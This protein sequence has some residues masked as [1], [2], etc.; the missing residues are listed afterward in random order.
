MKWL[1]ILLLASG[2]TRS[3][4]EVRSQY[5]NPS[6]LASCKVD[7]PDP[8]LLCFYGQEII[9]HYNAPI[10]AQLTLQVRM[11]DRTVRIFTK[12]LTK[13][14]GYTNWR[15]MAPEEFLSYKLELVHEGKVIACKRHHLWADIID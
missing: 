4:L 5:L 15:V 3:A 11:C 9:I 1:F 2:C 13:S 7:T 10:P 6:Y 8:N 12:Q 14:S